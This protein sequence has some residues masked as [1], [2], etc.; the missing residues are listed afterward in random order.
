MQDKAV[1]HKCHTATHRAAVQR[2]F[3]Q[4]VCMA[5]CMAVDIFSFRESQYIIKNQRIIENCLPYVCWQSTKQYRK[6]DVQLLLF[7]TL[8][9][10]NYS[11]PSGATRVL[12]TYTS[13]CKWLP[14]LSPVLPTA[15]IVCPWVT[16]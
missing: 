15:A 14:V 11:Q 8:L 9:Y 6:T 2:G 12:L 1:W 3:L 16:V 13:K 7:P 4:T 5:V 10:G